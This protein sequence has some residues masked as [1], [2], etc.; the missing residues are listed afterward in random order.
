[1]QLNQQPVAFC[2]SFDG[3]EGNGSRSGQLDGTYWGTSRWTQDINTNAGQSSAW[4]KSTMVGC[5][6]SST[7]QPENDIIVCNGQMRESTNDNPTGVFEAGG[8][9]AMTIYPKQQFSFANRTGTIA[10]DVTD[11]TQ[12]G[13]GAW[14]ELWITDSPKPTPFTLNGTGVGG[15][16]P[17]NGFGIRFDGIQDPAANLWIQNCP[18]DG[19][20][21]TGVG[22]IIPI[23]NYAIYD[24]N[25]GPLPSGM[26]LK[27]LGCVIEPP[28]A[29]GGLNHVEVQISQNQIDVFMTDA[30]TTSPLVHVAQITGAGMTLTQGLVWIEDVHYNADKSGLQPLQHDHTF[31]W[32]NFAFDGPIIARDLSFDVLDSLTA[33]HQGMVCLGWQSFSNA[34]MAAVS[35]MPMTAANIAASQAQFLMFDA[36]S[37]Y[38][39]IGTF[40]YVINGHKYTAAYPYTFP[41]SNGRLI[42]YMLPINAS[43]LVAGPNTVQI[44]SDQYLQIANINIELT[45]AGGVVPPD[46]GSLPPRQIGTKKK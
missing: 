45:G 16:L 10:F 41:S 17:A 42:S 40:S 32:D 23:R 5:S 28:D 6:G 3:P 44:W 43:D 25:L 21:R 38:N 2:E 18:N 34:P 7:V 26:S 30:G 31:T 33:C 15:T 4:A 14:P 19:K 39:Q 24:S 35:T 13:H 8:I 9:T 11:D 22:A 20:R 27:I 37:F 12:G 29:N 1:M 36:L 46:S